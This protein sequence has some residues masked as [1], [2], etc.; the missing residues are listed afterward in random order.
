MEPLEAAPLVEETLALHRPLAADA[1]LTLE[2]DI[3]KG[4]PAIQGDRDRL[5]QV[6]SNLIGN[7]IRFS[8]AGGRIVVRAVADGA[9]VRFSVSDEGPGIPR[10]QWPR[11]F[12]PFWQAVQGS[13]KG[14]G[15]GL[16]IAKG[17]VES[18]GGRIWVA[19]EPGQGATFHFTV[20]TASRIP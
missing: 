20:P 4:L 10:S 5:L 3:A 7:A 16:P 12:D 17:L 11:L 14:A 18:H 2:A 15:L 8:P 1:R 19:S 13:G 9:H 6:F